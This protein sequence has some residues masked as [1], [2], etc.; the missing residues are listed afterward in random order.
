MNGGAQ[1]TKS[2]FSRG[3][4]SVQLPEEELNGTSMNNR[5][6]HKQSNT[7]WGLCHMITVDEHFHGVQIRSRGLS[8][9]VTHPKRYTHVS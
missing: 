3:S 5:I 9:A 2:L 1:V 8:F 6:M 7:S 4:P